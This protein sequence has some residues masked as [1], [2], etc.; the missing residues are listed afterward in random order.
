M[1][2]RR[3]WKTRHVMVISDEMEKHTRDFTISAWLRHLATE[4]FVFNGIDVYWNDGP[5]K[6]PIQDLSFVDFFQI[7]DKEKYQHLKEEVQYCADRC[8]E[9][10][11]MCHPNT[12][13]RL[14]KIKF[15]PMNIVFY[16]RRYK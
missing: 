12:K 1:D 8:I 13:F 15:I 10:I 5:H 16:V 6:K 3:K 2:N 14:T 11:E 9:L 7:E 4:P